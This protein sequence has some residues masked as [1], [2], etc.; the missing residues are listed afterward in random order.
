MVRVRG[1]K[2][3]EGFTVELDF[4]DGSRRV[5]DLEPYLHGP[6]F[7][8][9][10]NDPTF[11]RSVC[12]DRVAGTIVWPNGA[13]ICPDVLYHGRTPSHMEKARSQG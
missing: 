3:L 12:V 13:D 6:V 11:F 7:E 4:T 5:I 9:V 1:V 10:R 2:V 8:P